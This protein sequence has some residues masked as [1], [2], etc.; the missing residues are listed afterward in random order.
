MTA[1][2]LITTADERSWKF[3]RPVLFLGEWCRRYSRKHIWEEMDAVVAEPYGSRIAKKERDLV[4]IQNLTDQLLAEV[5]DALNAVHCTNHD[6]RYW[7]I[8]FG[9]WLERYVCTMFNRYFTLEKALNKHEVS[10]TI[11]FDPP[12]YSLA[13]IDSETSVRACNDDLW[14]HVLYS[15]ILQFL[16]GVK[17]EVDPVPLQGAQGY[18]RGQRGVVPTKLTAKRF[19]GR[20][21]SK[22][23][24]KLARETDAF[25]IN[26]YL[27]LRE[28]IKL[29][30]RLG[31]IP[32]LWRSPSP[33]AVKPDPRMRRH[34]GL[35]NEGGDRFEQFLRIELPD[36]IPSCYL[37]GHFE[38]IEQLKSL[39]WPSSPRFI[40]TSNNYNI[41]EVFKV[42]AATKA[43]QG[44]PYFT[45]QHG[46]NYG[47]HF[48][49]AN[50]HRPEQ[51]T[52]DRLFTWGWSDGS[53]RVVPAFNFK[54]AGREIGHSDPRGGVLLIESVVPHRITPWD[55]YYEFG[56]RQEDQI[57]FAAALPDAI[58]KRL[59][60][61]LHKEYRNQEWSDIE[62]WRDRL[63]EV[64]VEPGMSAIQDLIAKSRLVVHGYDS[65]GM[66]ETLAGNI[67]TI[68]FWNY[69]L[70]QLTPS[71]RPFF[72][73][74]V[75]VGIIFE[76]PEDAARKVVTHWDNVREWWRSQEV[77]EARLTFCQ[78]YSKLVDKPSKV[79]QQLL[80]A[81]H[82]EYVK[83][84]PHRTGRSG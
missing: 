74:L 59:T 9:H 78:R 65:T 62:R 67:P 64:R 5:S 8:V 49:N 21:A 24:P 23:L 70:E 61:R 7:K 46:A 69:G 29:Q 51:T 14:N 6:M 3:D 33:V 76:N 16:G 75:R 20:L 47:T 25:I 2:F 28:E 26:S 84:I 71:A 19:V 48:F 53:S 1:R 56:L 37:E 30:L 40:F 55:N 41:D 72:E 35:A 18:V 17:I 34:F 63:P 22:I 82:Q 10:G 15:R 77:Q 31:Q 60:V 58:Q 11:I 54:I 52:S 42:W 32:Q 43:E 45:G 39:P 13:T 4:Y 38:I 66:L 57:R 27:P 81:N 83:S 73:N 44:T 68:A 50:S 12:D 36:V 80:A 79:L